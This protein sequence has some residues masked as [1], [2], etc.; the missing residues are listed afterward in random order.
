M[1]SYALSGTSASAPATPAQDTGR[2]KAR[3][4]A[5]HLSAPEMKKLDE[6]RVDDDARALARVQASRPLKPP[7]RNQKDRSST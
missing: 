4:A 1:K 3:A 6:Q 2:H 7:H 5:N